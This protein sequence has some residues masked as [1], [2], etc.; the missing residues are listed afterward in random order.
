[1]RGSLSITS[2]ALPLACFALAPQAGAQATYTLKPTPK[3]VAWSQCDAEFWTEFPG[4]PRNQLCERVGPAQPGETSEVPIGGVEGAPI[5]DGQRRQVGVTD[6]RTA[7]L[8]IQ[9][10]LPEQ[11]PVLISG[12]QETHVRLLHPLI[13]NLDGFLRREPLSRESWVRDDPKKGRHRLP[14]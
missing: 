4:R 2:G 12:W 8:A 3:T 6:Q 14:W 9:Q 13:Y 5:L 10:H 1:M 7:S 11:A